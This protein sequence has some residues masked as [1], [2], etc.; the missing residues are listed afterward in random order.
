ML[1]PVEMSVFL[2][3]DCYTID[4]YNSQYCIL[5]RSISTFDYSISAFDYLHLDQMRLTLRS[6]GYHLRDCS[7]SESAPST[8]TRS[9]EGLK[10]QKLTWASR[11]PD[12]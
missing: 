1:E 10:V 8:V 2:D 6:L 9:H 7:A 5:A 12:R 4:G 3:G 11:S